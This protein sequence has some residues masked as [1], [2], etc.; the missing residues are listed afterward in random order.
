MTIQAKKKRNPVIWF[1][2]GIVLVVVVT[3]IANRR[4]GLAIEVQFPLNNGVAYLYTVGERLVA[5]CHDNKVYVWDWN[6]LSAR[7]KVIEARSD[8]AVLLESGRVASVKRSNAQDVVI[9]DLNNG[10]TDAMMPINA[11]NKQVYLAANRSGRFVTAVLIS[12]D[13]TARGTGQEVVVVDCVAGLVRPI[14][15]LGNA[16]MDR[17]MGT[18]VSDDG[19]F[20]V[21]VGEKAGKG[22]VVLVSLKDKRVTW[23]K[24][25]PD[26]QKVR[27]AVFSTDGRVIDIRGTDSTVQVLD[28]EKGAVLKQLL[29]LSENKSTAGDQHVQTLATSPDGRFMAASISSTVYVWNCKT[30]KVIFRKGPGHK[31]TGGMIFSP[32]S[33]FLATCDSR[34]GGPIR[35]WRVPNR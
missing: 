16:A 24:E 26:L 14:V 11:R 33:K 18:A 27:N 31:L 1:G 13:D 17:I 34:Q 6:S 4:S 5:V 3:L 8:Q 10:N 21:L 15:E 32:D 29:P 12:T 23:T 30:E 22:V 28:T 19:C 35:V 7:P 2:L 25:L 20:I 9:A